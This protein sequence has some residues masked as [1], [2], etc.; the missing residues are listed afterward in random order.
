M[1]LKSLF[2]FDGRQEVS[3]AALET[4]LKSIPSGVLVVEKISEK[5]VYVNDRFVEITGFNPYGLSLREYALDMAKV[6]RFDNSPFLYEQLPLTKALFCGKTTRNQEIIIHRANHS[7]LIVLVNAK[8][9][10]DNK[11]EITGAIAVF[12][13]IT[14]RKKAEESLKEAQILLQEYASDLEQRV[15]E[16]AKKI[17]E[18]EQSYRELYESF[19]E[20][21]IATDWELNV[22][23]WNKVAERVSSVPAKVALGKKIYEVMPEMVSVDIAPYLETLQQKK[24]ARFMMNTK[25]RETKKP[26]IFEISA[27]PSAQG[28]IIIVEDKTKEEETKRLSTI[29]QVAG[30]VGHD[31]RNPL[32]AILGDVYLL[33]EYLKSMPEMQTKN[34]VKE[35][36]EGIAQNVEYVNKIVADLQDYVKPLA[37]N[38]RETNI[39]MAFDE[40]LIKK[41]I[42]ENIE[43]S[44]KI[45]AEAR[46]S[47]SDPDLLKR[48]LA[49]LVN[50]AVQAMPKGGKLSVSAIREGND[51]IIT[52]EDTGCGIAENVKSKLFTPLFTTKSKGQGFGL[53]AAKRMTEA[54][55]GTITFESETGKGTKFMVSLPASGKANLRA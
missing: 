12:E 18:S 49:N 5:I 14:E 28:I 1:S 20:A 26:S 31:I 22:T 48:V 35:S 40:I 54:L 15:E 46:R 8:P 2:V 23:H 7:K 29:G 51:L 10:T 24:P 17:I 45:Q 38:L 3:S 11:G 32:Q 41:A 4:I 19:G 25:S 43:V 52:I 55:G 44:R 16:R 37:P 6:H 9:L 47:V 36:L 27:Y 21:F 39:E 30:M 34:D 33:K 53:A 42:P 13:D 50:N